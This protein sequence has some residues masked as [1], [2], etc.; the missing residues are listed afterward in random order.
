M[1]DQA[2]R[3]DLEIPDPTVAQRAAFQE[4]FPGVI[5][6]DVIDA[7]KLGELLGLDVAQASD[8]RERFGLS[9][10]GKSDAIASLR[11]PSR[12]TLVPDMERS[13]SFDTAENVFIEGDNLEV[14][15]LLQKSYN[16]QVKMIYIDPPYNTGKDFVYVDDFRD[17]LQTYLLYSGQVGDDGNR[18]SAA[19]DATGRRHSR[20]LSM[21]YPRLVLARNLLTQDGVIFISIDDNEVAQLRLMLDEIFG[22][23]NFVENYIWESNFRPDNSSAVERENSQHVLC[24]CRNKT[25]LGRLVGA[26]KKSEGLPSLTKNSMG[27][28]TIELQPDW[29]DFGLQDGDYA[30]GDK[31]S[32]YTLEDTVSVR[33]GKAT[34]P[35][36]L[37]GRI[38]WS[39]VYLADQAAAGTRII[40]KG[41]G[42]VPYSR[43]SETAPLPPTSLISRDDAGDVLA[44][45]AELRALFGAVPFN[46][47][48]PT[49]LVKY[50]VHAVTYDDKQALILDFFAGSGSA[51]HAVSTLNAED[52]GRRKT[53][54][55]NLP[56][57]VGVGTTAEEM[58]FRYVSDISIERIKRV[59]QQDLLSQAQ[60]LRVFDLSPSNFIEP[61]ADLST[62][63]LNDHTLAHVPPD[64]EAVVEEVLIKEGVPHVLDLP[65][66]RLPMGGADAVKV[67]DHLVVTSLDLNDA[68]I[69][70]VINA[71]PHVVVFCED[72]FAGRDAVK[73]NAF[74]RCQQAGITMKTV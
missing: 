49:T 6:D 68:V 59:M 23:E 43:K 53:I 65:R 36:R 33:G 16:D 51:A 44:G 4:L 47:P 5:V 66:Y 34:A 27:I 10:A 7:D 19:S 73:A 39:Q 42:F 55:V 28:T 12:A 32:G 41:R 61:S 56:E 48:K 31:G 14:L 57:P 20:W 29:V 40:I 17:P 52:G 3:V 54:S 58:G 2:D 64:W 21:M 25:C 13:I 35:F 50:L 37:S 74:W 15:K 67:A 71:K 24:Y 72:G 45:N 62:L 8:G 60:G 38:I 70:A 22:E 46:H 9:W 18:L 63:L 69:D 11:V 1:S 30:P 26:Q